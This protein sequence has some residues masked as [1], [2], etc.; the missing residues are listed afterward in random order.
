MLPSNIPAEWITSLQAQRL[1][2]E[3]SDLNMI[4][5][6]KDTSFHEDSVQ[7]EGDNGPGP[8]LQ[9]V[10]ETLREAAP[11]GDEQQTSRI[12]AALLKQ[13]EEQETGD[14]TTPSQRKKK[15]C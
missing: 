6:P 9:A 11:E 12:P 3:S 7:A 15:T 10:M 2:I 1:D 14:T 5:F 13:P 8:R 4:L